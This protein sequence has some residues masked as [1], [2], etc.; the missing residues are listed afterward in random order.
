MNSRKFRL[1]AKTGNFDA[2]RTNTAGVEVKGRFFFGHAGEFRHI[3]VNP[4][5]SIL[6]GS[7][8]FADDVIAFMAGAIKSNPNISDNIKAHLVAFVDAMDERAVGR[9]AYDHNVE[10]AALVW[11]NGPTL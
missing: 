1:F 10:E 5:G 7:K 11:V 3:T 6:I 9:H 2:C 8:A 4:D